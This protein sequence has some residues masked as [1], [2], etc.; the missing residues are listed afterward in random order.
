MHVIYVSPFGDNPYI[1]ETSFLLMHKLTIIDAETDETL[2]VMD[3]EF[4]PVKGQKIVYKASKIGSP[5]LLV[6]KIIRAEVVDVMLNTIHGN[7]QIKVNI[8]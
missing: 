7:V 3:S 8:L 5:P 1:K 2:R 4:V 6:P